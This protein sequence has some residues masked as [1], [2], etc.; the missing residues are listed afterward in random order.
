MIAGSG[1]I[2]AAL[3]IF[4]DITEAEF[5]AKTHLHGNFTPCH[6]AIGFIPFRRHKPRFL[7]GELGMSDY[8]K[9]RREIIRS[10]AI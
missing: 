7:K 3:V 1:C 10:I 5:R 6:C 9:T 2:R 8:R 4:T